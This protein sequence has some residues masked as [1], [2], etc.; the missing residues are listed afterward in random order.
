[1]LEMVVGRAGISTVATHDEQTPLKAAE[2][3]SPERRSISNGR[4]L[5]RLARGDQT[6]VEI[7]RSYAVSHMT[8]SRLKERHAAS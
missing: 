7:A 2:S 5:A 4:F 3:K 8:I 6:L 1:M